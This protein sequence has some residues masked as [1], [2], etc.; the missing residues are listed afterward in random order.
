MH[1]TR[2][3]FRKS[4][5]KEH[6]DFELLTRLEAAIIRHAKGWERFVV[7][8]PNLLRQSIDEVIDAS[9]SRRFVFSELQSTEKAYVGTKVEILL[10]NHLGLDRGSVLDVLVDGIEVDI[11][12]TI[13]DNW[14]IPH[15]ALG[16]PC[17][18]IQTNE[19]SA[20]CSFGLVVIQDDILTRGGNQDGKK[21]LTATG[22]KSVHWMLRDCDYPRNF[23]E[24][25]SRDAMRAITAPKGGTERL[26]VLF[27]I[28]QRCPIHRD[29]L[30]ALA[31]Q[32]D[33]MKRLRKNGGARDKLQHEGIAVLSGKYHGTLISRLGLKSCGP[34]EFIS[35]K[36]SSAEEKEMLQ[37][38]GE[39]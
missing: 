38:A 31:H 10:M 6:R 7:D 32:K 23:W 26:A 5:D 4:L 11:K 17:V 30:I 34:D 18:L 39:L 12:N 2:L 8:I 15:E 33:A 37:R 14:M 24:D 36:P 1:L 13:G 20:K 22:K 29:V 9:R 21:T 3:G 19:K 25:V 28:Y 16:H 35:V 27:Q